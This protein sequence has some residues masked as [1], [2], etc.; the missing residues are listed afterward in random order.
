[1]IIAQSYNIQSLTIIR[2]LTHGCSA[3]SPCYIVL[4]LFAGLLNSNPCI[5][6]IRV[7][8]LGCSACSF[9]YLGW[10]RSSLRRDHFQGKASQR[11]PF[12]L[13]FSI[14]PRA[15]YHLL[16]HTITPR[17]LQARFSFTA[18]SV[19]YIPLLFT[20]IQTHKKYDPRSKDERDTDPKIIHAAVAVLQWSSNC[21]DGD[22]G[23]TW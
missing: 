22:T 6:I 8:T 4:W 5:T 14:I 15:A 10:L 9:Y 21:D 3:Y 2:V 19:Q 17:S 11:Q 20:I 23:D 18:P 16:P 13:F 7:L 12:D 1:M